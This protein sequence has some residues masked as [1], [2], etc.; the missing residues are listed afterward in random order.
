MIKTIIKFLFAAAILYWLFQKGDLDFS[1]IKKSWA[2]PENWIMGYALILLGITM[3]IIRWRSLL[4]TGTDKKFSLSDISR[5]TWIGLFFSAVLPGAVTGDLIKLLYAKDLDRGFSKTFLLMSVFMDR[6]IGLMG[7]LFILG[8]SSLIFY[9]DI[10][11]IDPKL[12]TIVYLNLLIFAGMVTFVC[13]LFVPKKIQTIILELVK[14]IPIIGNRGSYTLTQVWIFGKSKRL[15][16]QNIFISAV[17]QT[18]NIMAFWVLAS[19]FFNQPLSLKYAFTFVPLGLVAIAI[20]IS[21]AGVGVGHA[22]FNTLFGHYGITNGASLFNLF[23]IGYFTI[24]IL[25]IIP[26]LMAGKRHTLHEAD[27][28]EHSVS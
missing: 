21:P 11:N 12:K 7:L 25:G 15:V 18:S 6:V 26:Y 22:I 20:P 1:L 4:H 8:F 27:E 24:N 2:S 19:P 10:V 28:L 17:A 23:F 14:K 3:G 13:L 16:L 5:L 9:N